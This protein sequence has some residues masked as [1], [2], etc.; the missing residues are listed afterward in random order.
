MEA[1]SVGNLVCDTSSVIV[2]RN[3]LVRIP[4]RLGLDVACVYRGDNRG[5]R[6]QE[7]WTFGG[8]SLHHTDDVHLLV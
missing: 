5:L 1:D 2:G 7:T 6:N 8:Y 3:Q 4:Y